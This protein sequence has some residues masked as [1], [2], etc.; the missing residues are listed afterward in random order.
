MSILS[1]NLHPLRPA[2]GESRTTDGALTMRSHCNRNLSLRAI[3]W[4]G[5][6]VAVIHLGACGG[7]GGANPGAGGQVPA[8]NAGADQSVD[9]GEMVSL[10]GSAVDLS[11]SGL[12]YVWTQVSGPAVVLSD[13]TD[14]LATFTAP[15]VIG[16]PEVVTLRLTATDANGQSDSDEVSITIQPMQHFIHNAEA[17]NIIG[18]STFIDS[19]LTNGNP[20]A[21]L[22]VTQKYNGVYN[23][24]PIGVW[25]EGLTGRWAI[26]N[27]DIAVMPAGAEFNVR[28]VTDDPNAFVHTAGPGSI[29]NNFTRISHPELDGNPGARLLVTQNYNPGGAGGV[30]N[31]QPIGVWYTG[32]ERHSIYNQN[33]AVAMPV[34]ASFNVL[35]IDPAAETFVHTSEPGNITFHWTEIDHPMLNGNPDAQILFTHNYN[36]DGV[37]ATRIEEVLGAWYNAATERWTIFDQDAAGVFPADRHF[38]VLIQ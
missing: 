21:I 33:N 36:P 18:H 12:T 20:A 38:N 29:T 34:G 6:V 25:Y 4:L 28:V 7:S 11:G 8:A 10:A 32:T 15:A 31:A 19:P 5:L 35:I 24:H 37:G 9:S 1:R 27:Q 26:F 23:D 30:Y 16:S 3:A 2:T 22:I 14:P 13:A 17:G